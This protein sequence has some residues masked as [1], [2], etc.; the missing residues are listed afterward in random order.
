MTILYIR[1]LKYPHRAHG[2]DTS[3]KQISKPYLRG[4]SMFIY[5]LSGALQTGHARPLGSRAN[6]L[7]LPHSSSMVWP[8]GNRTL[9]WVIQSPQGSQQRRRQAWLQANTFP[10]CKLQRIS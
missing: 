7:I 5:L 6:F 4:I 10:H 8:H 2:T 9:I 1:Q 3:H